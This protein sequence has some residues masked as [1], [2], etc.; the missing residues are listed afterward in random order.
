MEEPQDCVFCQIVARKLPA[1]IVYEDDLVMAFMDIQPVNRGHTLVVPKTHAD[2][3]NDLDPDVGAELFQIAMKL[4]GAVRR[5]VSCDGVNLYVADG[6]VAGQDVFHFHLHI[7]PRHKGDGFGLRLPTGYSDL[8]ER[9]DLDAV[10][11]AIKKA[12]VSD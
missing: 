3:I 9:D 10:A 2:G 4:S 1:S 5:A 7:I 8:P 6:V 11:A 12:S